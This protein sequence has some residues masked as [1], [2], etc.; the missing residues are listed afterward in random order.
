ML[1]VHELY[2]CCTCMSNGKLKHWMNNLLSTWIGDN[3]CTKFLKSIPKRT[4][5]C[6]FTFFFPYQNAEMG[7][8]SESV[9]ETIEIF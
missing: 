7:F 3:T 2:V 1:N 5:F 4:F 9:Y 6:F 8:C